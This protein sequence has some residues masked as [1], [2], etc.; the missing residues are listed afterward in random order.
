MIC[1]AV[2]SAVCG[3]WCQILAPPEPNLLRWLV[4]QPLRQPISGNPEKLLGDLA[5]EQYRTV[6]L[7]KGLVFFLEK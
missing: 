2:C 4:V 7:E 6:V 5:Q 1:F 3:P